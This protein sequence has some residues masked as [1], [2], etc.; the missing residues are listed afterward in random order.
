MATI[1]IQLEQ[2][3]EPPEQRGHQQH[4]AITILHV[5]RRHQRAQHQTQRIDQ[6]MALLSLDQFAG[7]EPMWIDASPPFSELFTLRLSTMHAV[8]LASRSTCSRHFT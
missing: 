3:R 8:E 6:D 7:I 4:T 5:G 1:G 2:E